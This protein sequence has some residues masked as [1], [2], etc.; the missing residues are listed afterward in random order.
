MF[1]E[2]LSQCSGRGVVVMAFGIDIGIDIGLK[3][4]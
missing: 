3:R 1:Q 4:D 2:S